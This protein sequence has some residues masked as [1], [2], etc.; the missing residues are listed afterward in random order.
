M[1]EGGCKC[2]KQLKQFKEIKCIGVDEL[3]QLQLSKGMCDYGNISYVVLKQIWK[4]RC[5]RNQGEPQ[6]S[7]YDERGLLVF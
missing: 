4:E 7:V 2:D 6:G 5:L 1:P 3:E